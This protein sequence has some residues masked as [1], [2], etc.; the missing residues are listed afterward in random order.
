MI[1]KICSKCRIP[2]DLEDFRKQKGKRLDKASF[3]R[4]C[5][6]Q[7][8]H[9]YYLKNIDKVLSRNAAWKNAP[10]NKLRAS[11]L[12]KKRGKD[13]LNIRLK[14][15]LR[16]RLIRTVRSE[17]KSGSA[18]SDLGCSVEDLKRHIESKF[19][20]SMNWDNWGKG[21]GKWNIDHIV[22]LYRF[23]LTNRQHFILAN[24]YLNLQPLWFED[25]MAKNRKFQPASQPN[26]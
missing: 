9:E 19:E 26:N 16:S 15:A 4:A 6:K 11:E 8:K 13:N 22:P 5:E 7:Y 18:I 23:D 25:N 17:Y 2:K 3:C 1:I 21:H 10:E 12:H 20:S 14:R 24:Y